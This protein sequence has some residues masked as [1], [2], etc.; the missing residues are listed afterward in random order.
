MLSVNHDITLYFVM[1]TQGH[2]KDVVVLINTLDNTFIKYKMK[3]LGGYKIMMFQM[4][5][6][7]DLLPIEA[8]I[9]F[10]KMIG[11]YFKYFNNEGHELIQ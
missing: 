1:V 11:H 2:R 9:F 6:C 5:V 3:Y 7:F 10:L 8:T 4:L